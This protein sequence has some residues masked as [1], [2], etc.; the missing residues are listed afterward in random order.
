MTS[1]LTPNFNILNFLSFLD[2]QVED[3]GGLVLEVQV[4]IVIEFVNDNDPELLL[5]GSNYLRDYQVDF[6]EGQDHLGGADPVSLSDN[7]LIVDN[8]AD[9]QFLSSATINIQDSEKTCSM[10]KILCY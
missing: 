9:P 6:F 7:L 3:M 5:D 2:S 8:D 10:S 1:Q 4:E